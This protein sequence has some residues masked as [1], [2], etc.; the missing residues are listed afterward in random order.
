MNFLFPALVFSKLTVHVD[1]EILPQP[2]LSLVA[3]IGVLYKGYIKTDSFAYQ[4]LPMN[5]ILPITSLG[6]SRQ[7]FQSSYWS[8]TFQNCDFMLNVNRSPRQ[9]GNVNIVSKKIDFFVSKREKQ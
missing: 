7:F 5:F 8:D 1:Y 6:S 3:L 9:R 2:V 4:L